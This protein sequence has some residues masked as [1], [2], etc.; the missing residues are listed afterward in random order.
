MNKTVKLLRETLMIGFAYL[1]SLAV[2][3]RAPFERN[4]QDC[5]VISN[6]SKKTKRNGNTALNALFEMHTS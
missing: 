6:I 3:S 5:E 2:L 1:F 4:L